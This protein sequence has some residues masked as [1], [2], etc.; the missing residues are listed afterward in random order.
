MPH[1]S[2]E[3]IK[4]ALV[5]QLYKSVQW[6]QTNQFFIDKGILNIAECGPGKVLSGLA[7]RTHRTWNIYSLNTADGFNQAVNAGDQES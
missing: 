2:P 6:T 3:N 4:K 5:E 7:K 1:I